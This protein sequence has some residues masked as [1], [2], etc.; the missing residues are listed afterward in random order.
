MKIEFE[1]LVKE[2][3]AKALQSLDK[4]FEVKLQGESKNMEWLVKAP[5]DR[6]VK[7]TI[8]IEDGND[9]C[10]TGEC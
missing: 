2:F 3:K 7:V 5:A 1:A 8:E 4:G 9:T 6:T 10:N